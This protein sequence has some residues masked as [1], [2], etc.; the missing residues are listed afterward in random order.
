MILWL[1]RCVI[2]PWI[3]YTA[4]AG[5][6]N[7]HSFGKF[8]V[9]TSAEGCIYYYY[10]AKRTAPTNVLEIFLDLPT[11]GMAVES[12]S[13]MVAYH[14]PRPDPRNLGI[15]HNQIW[16]KTHEVD[17]KFNMIKDHIT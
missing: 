7:G 13:L 5:W 16:A 17:N 3:I 8:R 6:D 10:R 9:K 12:A 1:Y 11:L 4:V 15:G 14:L 2:I